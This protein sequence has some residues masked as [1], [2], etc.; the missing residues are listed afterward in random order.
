M[1]YIVSHHNDITIK[2]KKPAQTHNS[3]TVSKLFWSFTGKEGT[4][5]NI[6]S[7]LCINWELIL[8]QKTTFS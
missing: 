6:P 1:A 4:G 5:F 2:T 7:E 8:E 3:Y